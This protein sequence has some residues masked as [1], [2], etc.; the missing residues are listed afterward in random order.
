MKLMHIVV[1]NHKHCFD[2]CLDATVSGIFMKLC[3]TG[4]FYFSSSAYSVSGAEMF[5]NLKIVPLYLFLFSSL[6]LSLRAKMFVNLKIK[7]LWP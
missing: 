5:E 3:I 6:L 1:I 2:G 7:K 4:V